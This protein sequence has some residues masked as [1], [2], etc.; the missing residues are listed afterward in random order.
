MTEVVEANKEEE[1]GG[2]KP[3]DPFFGIVFP[4]KF[5]KKIAKRRSALGLIPHIRDPEKQEMLLSTLKSSRK[6]K[7]GDDKLSCSQEDGYVL[8]RATQGFSNKGKYY[9]EFIFNGDAGKS[10]CRLGIATLKADMEA[11]VG[12]DE[13][14]YSVRDSGGA[15]HCSF[16]LTEDQYPDKKPFAGFRFNDVVG[17]GFTLTDEP[18]TTTLEVW[19]NGAYQ[20]VIFKDIDPNKIWYPALSCYKGAK[21]T[22][23][24]K[25]FSHP[26]DGW[27]P[28]YE[29]KPVGSVGEYS[30]DDLIH[31]MEKG[32]EEN[33]TQ[34]MREA[35][36]AVLAPLLEMPY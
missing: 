25:N 33:R 26:I 20:G 24:F 34:A 28:A 10:H 32:T 11:P 36:F 16:M 12:V 27:T 4:L 5:D 23:R 13:E 7:F 35:V 21:V 22:A 18:E 19:I 1:E 8:A 30:S 3:I 29:S 6:Y 17:F 15:F 14:G 9:W 31:F 2:E